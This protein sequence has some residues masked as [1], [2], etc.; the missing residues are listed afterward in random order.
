MI[1]D[2]RTHNLV[3]PDS[4][5]IAEGMARSQLRDELED[6]VSQTQTLDVEME[7]TLSKAPDS[8]SS[9]ADPAAAG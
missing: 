5:R 9:K 2:P 1:V 8:D 3:Y 4:Y 6:C 7:V